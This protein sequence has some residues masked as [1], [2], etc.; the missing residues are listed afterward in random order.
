MIPRG[1]HL[2]LGGEGGLGRMAPLH[3]PLPDQM[4]N[5]Y[6]VTHCWYRCCTVP[7]VGK[8]GRLGGD[9]LRAVTSIDNVHWLI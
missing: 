2:T 7:Y 6:R 4:D 8:L 9:T 1:S 3:Y 5:L